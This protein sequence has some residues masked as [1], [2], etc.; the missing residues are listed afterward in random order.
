MSS[1]PRLDDLIAP[2]SSAE[3]VR[4]VHEVAA[5]TQPDR[6][7]WCDGSDGEAATLTRLLLDT[8]A[9][10]TLH[11]D[12]PGCHLYRSHP[13]DVARVEHLTF[14]CTRDQTDAGPNNYWMAPA[15]AHAHMDSLFSGCMR[16]RTLYVIPY[17]MGPLDSPFSRCGVEL[18]DSPYVVLNMRLM[19]RMGQ[20][21]LARLEREGRFVRGLH[22][23][24]DLDPERRFI[25]HFPEELMI[26]SFGSGYG[27]NALLGKKCHALRIA[28]WQAREEG[29]LAEHML[30]VAITNPAGETHY[31]AAAFP[32]ACGKTNLAMLIPPASM[33]APVAAETP[34]PP[35]IISPPRCSVRTGKT[36][37]PGGSP[38]S[39]VRTARI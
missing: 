33:P 39:D 12:Y 25:M 8:G 20:D 21:A 2:T 6:I 35:V 27:G 32:S 15:A 30:L 26:K 18:T 17:C 36:Y 4:W 1:L 23:T 13:N 11:P 10:E 28:S 31:V 5:L 7:H 22:S 14:V 38:P 29:W 37:R 16:G 19:T 3:L 34:A 24:G 9:L